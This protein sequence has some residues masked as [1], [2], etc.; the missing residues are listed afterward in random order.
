MLATLNFA[1]PF[2]LFSENG[3]G[4]RK[5]CES[6]YVTMKKQMILFVASKGIEAELFDQEALP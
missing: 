2:L 6:E 1:I 4:F 5:D 3:L